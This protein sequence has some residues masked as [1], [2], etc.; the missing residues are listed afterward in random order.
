MSTPLR[1]IESPELTASEAFQRALDVAAEHADD[2]DRRGRF[3]SEAVE[4]L[5]S[6]GALGWGVPL[7]YGGAGAGIDDLAD[8]T[9]ELSRRCSATGMIFAMH[10]IQIASIVRHLADSLWFRNYL[11]RVVRE[12][13]LIASATSEV[14]VGG[15][16]RKSIAAVTPVAEF[17]GQSRPVRKEGLDDFLRR[18]RRRST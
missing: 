16:M 5:R 3:P 9:F 18:P 7:E 14:G 4:A 13:R 17:V 8:A 2:V 12:Q 11:R 10:Q 1:A 15:D 6:A